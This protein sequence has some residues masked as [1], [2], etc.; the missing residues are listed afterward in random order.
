MRI[1]KLIK[2]KQLRPMINIRN[3]YSSIMSTSNKIPTSRCNSSNRSYASLMDLDVFLCY[4]ARLIEFL[5]PPEGFHRSITIPRTQVLLS[6][7]VV[8]NLK[9]IGPPLYRQ[10]LLQSLIF[11][12]P[13]FNFLIISTSS[14]R[15]I[16]YQLQTPDPSCL[17]SLQRL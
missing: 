17:L 14:N 11:E 2:L 8:D 6:F 16:I 7:L 1:M 4:E 15:I 3:H 9:A 13:D 12:I 10:R 5:P